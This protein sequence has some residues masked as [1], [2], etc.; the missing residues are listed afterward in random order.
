VLKETAQLVAMPTEYPKVSSSNPKLGKIFFAW[1][2]RFGGQKWNTGSIDGF[3]A[4]VLNETS[5]FTPHIS[6]GDS[7]K[8]WK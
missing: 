2:L 3:S 8:E 7:K 1:I 6:H 4:E 5:T